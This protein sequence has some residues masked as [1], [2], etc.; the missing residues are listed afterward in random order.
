[1]PTVL[2]TGASQGLG[3][4]IARQYAADGWRVI[5]TCRSPDAAREL[6]ALASGAGPAIVERLD[7]TDAAGV[8]ALARKYAA[9]PID[10]LLNNAGIM[11][12][13]PFRDNLHRQ[14]F[15][16]IDYEL[17]DQVFRTNTL[18][19]VKVTE[20]F[21]GSVARST[22]K[23]IV[24]LSST[25]GS[26]AESRREALAYTTSKTALNKAMTLIA[27]RLK[28]QGIIVALVCPGYVMT[29]MNV[30]GAT[31]GI[32]ESVAGMRRLIAGLTLEDSGTFRRYNGETVAW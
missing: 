14:H 17:W 2:V 24:C 3:L 32:P 7:V 29:R 21:V 26:I 13:L 9:E 18:G 5:A 19:T 22:L 25:T 8:D 28:P 20:A 6:A 30:G 11:G 15:G 23:K 12:A 27:E 31:L 4:E 16:S 10:L 1:V